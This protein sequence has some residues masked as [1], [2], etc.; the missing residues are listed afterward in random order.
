MNIDDFKLKH[1]VLYTKGWY[2]LSWHYKNKHK[3]YLD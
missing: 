3:D 2:H 1:F